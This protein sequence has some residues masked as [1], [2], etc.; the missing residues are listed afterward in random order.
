[1]EHRRVSVTRQI[2]AAPSAIFDLLADARQHAR[3]DGSGT[4]V[5]VRS[6][7][8]RLFLGARFSMS[9]RIGLRYLTTNRVSA[10]EPDR[11]IAWHHAARFVWRY[12][13]EPV[14]G[15]TRVTESFTY[16]Q[17]WGIVIEWLGWPERNRRSM[18]AT[19]ERLE[20]L[21]TAPPSN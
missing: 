19:L 13:L 17:P 21:A 11:V 5:A 20:A 6:A 12:D 2:G 8:E 16:D 14:D 4:V 18:A 15:G 9:M 1:M 7:P 3:F 10:F